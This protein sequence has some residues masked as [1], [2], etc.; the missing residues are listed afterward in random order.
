MYIIQPS[1]NS[2]LEFLICRYNVPSQLVR[3]PTTGHLVTVVRYTLPSYI[4]SNTITRIELSPDSSSLLLASSTTGAICILDMHLIKSA[5]ATSHHT[6][7][8]SNTSMNAHEWPLHAITQASCHTL[9]EGLINVSHVPDKSYVST[10]PSFADIAFYSYTHPFTDI[11]VDTPI[12]AV[13]ISSSGIGHSSPLPRPTHYYLSLTTPANVYKFYAPHTINK[14]NEILGKLLI[15]AIPIST[16]SSIS[17][18]SLP[19]SAHSLGPSLAAVGEKTDGCPDEAVFNITLDHVMR[20]IPLKNPFVTLQHRPILPHLPLYRRAVP[21]ILYLNN[22]GVLTLYTPPISYA[23]TSTFPGPMYPEG[24][25]VMQSLETYIEAEDELDFVIRTNSLTGRFEKVPAV[26]SLYKNMAHIQDREIASLSE[27]TSVFT[28]LSLLEDTARLSVFKGP[29]SGTKKVTG[30]KGG[31][32][33][34]TQKK[35]R[36]TLSLPDPHQAPTGTAST[37]DTHTEDARLDTGTSSSLPTGSDGN[38]DP[39]VPMET[40]DESPHRIASDTSLDPPDS[41]TIHKRGE[42]SVGGSSSSSSSTF[43]PYAFFFPVPKRVKN[44]EFQRYVQTHKEVRRAY[45]HTFIYNSA[46]P[47]LYLCVLYLCVYTDKHLHQRRSE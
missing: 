31:R 12:P 1:I 21:Y 33:G 23:Y 9:Y 42:A 4:Q 18:T 6:N 25:L 44:G 15:I 40:Y 30:R 3:V 34:N 27:G 24:Y 11:P 16:P 22:R 28:Q 20:Y 7:T 39:Q 14:A 29:I 19:T 5:T 37:I 2:S 47:T 43:N 41:T 26:A 45:I 35:R 36:K 10:M 8:N 46:Y 17:S 32:G 13:A 38:I